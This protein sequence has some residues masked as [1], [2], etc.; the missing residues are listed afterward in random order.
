MSDDPDGKKSSQAVGDEPRPAEDVQSP[1]ERRSTPP[2]APPPEEVHRKRRRWL[3]AAVVLLA[4]VGVGALTQLPPRDE[5]K[6]KTRRPLTNVVVRE[7]VARDLPDTIDL[8][9]VVEPDRTVRVPA[10]V[11]GTLVDVVCREGRPCTEGAKLIV[12][13]GERLA[14]QLAQAEALV[15]RMSAQIAQAKA[16]RDLAKLEVDTAATLVRQGAETD[17]TLKRATDALKAAEAGI[18]QAEAGLA[19]AEAARNAVKLD[20]GYTTISAPIDGVVDEVL[21]EKGELIAVGQPVVRIVDVAKM[22]VVVDVPQRDIRFVAPGQKQTVL[23][24][25]SAGQ[26]GPRLTGTVD[27]IGKLADPGAK[28]TRVELLVDNAS[29]DLHSGQPVRVRLHRRT[30]P[31]AIMVPLEAVI[32]LEN[33]RAVYVVDAEGKAQRRDVAL[34]IWR[35]R[36]VQIRSG[37]RAGDRLIVEG[38]R[39]VAQGQPVKVAEAAATSRPSSPVASKPPRP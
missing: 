29:G 8:P 3:G 36:E 39:Y 15:K 17:F 38:H 24:D 2:P 19:E 16:N 7:V 35:G 14:V 23:S 25:F 5:N 9:G 10:R 6:P 27:Y 33:G 34:G 11:S 31:Q 18:K 4:A 22:R 28:T 21:F 20:Q 1:A 13:D 12:L 32:P 37:L 26:D 30:I